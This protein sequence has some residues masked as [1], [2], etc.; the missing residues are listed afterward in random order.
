MGKIKRLIYL[1]TTK[2]Q[3]GNQHRMVMLTNLAGLIGG[4]SYIGFAIN[5]AIL[6]LTIFLANHFF[7][8]II[9][10]TDICDRLLQCEKEICFGQFFGRIF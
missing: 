7:Q 3:T 1:G 2:D 8:Y 4:L 5:Y 9:R 6:D 10:F